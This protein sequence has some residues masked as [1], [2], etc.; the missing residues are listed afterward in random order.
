MKE[1]NLI[2][3]EQLFIRLIERLIQQ[4]VDERD[5]FNC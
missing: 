4:S 2:V 3:I 1:L 5:S